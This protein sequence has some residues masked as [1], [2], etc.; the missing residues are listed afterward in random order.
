M[1]SWIFLSNHSSIPFF[2]GFHWYD[3]RHLYADLSPD[4]G[5]ICWLVGAWPRFKVSLAKQI[6]VLLA[7]LAIVHGART[8]VSLEV[9]WE[10]ARTRFPHPRDV[11]WV[12]LVH[13]LT[14]RAGYFMHFPVLRS[15]IYCLCIALPRGWTLH[16]T[17]LPK[18]L[19]VFQ[20]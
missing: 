5:T 9:V 20:R 10:G 1:N 4:N 14:L 13:G 12:Q 7:F 19:L 3:I 8:K 17:L 16:T 11:W 6:L 2:V 18:T 15:L